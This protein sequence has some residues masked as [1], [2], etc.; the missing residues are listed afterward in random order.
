LWLATL[1]CSWSIFTTNTGPII[2]IAPNELDVNDADVIALYKQ[3]RT[4]LKSEFYDGSTAIKPN[5]FGTRDED[6][7]ALRRRQMAHSFSTASMTRM[8]EISDRNVVNI[9]M[10]L[11]KYAKSREVF[12]LSTI[13]AFFG[14]DV[15][16]E[17]SYSTRYDSQKKDDP[18]NLLP[19]NEH[20]L[21]SCLIG[22]IPSL[23]PVLVKYGLFLPW[24]CDMLTGR[25]W[26]RDT[27]AANTAREYQNQADSKNY[28]LLTSLIKAKDPE[29]GQILEEVDV[30]TEAFAFL[31]AGS[32]TTYGSPVML[33]KHVFDRLDIRSTVCQE[34]DENLPPTAAG[35][36]PYPGL[37]AK[38]PHMSATMKES[39]RLTPIFQLPL[40]RV[41]P[42]GGHMM[43]GQHLP[44]GTIV[45]SINY[46]IGHNR[47]I[48]GSDVEE[49]DLN[50]WLKGE[51]ADPNMLMAFGAGHRACIGRNM[52]M[53]SMWKVSTALPRNYEFLP[54]P[55]TTGGKIEMEAKGFAELVG[56]L[57]CTC[58][59][60]DVRPHLNF[61]LYAVRKAPRWFYTVKGRRTTRMR[62]SIAAWELG[63][64]PCYGRVPGRKVDYLKSQNS[65]ISAIFFWTTNIYPKVLQHCRIA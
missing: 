12:D 39:F 32:H 31:V 23:K 19:I 37:E 46:C 28:N 21:L 59:F 22:V 43:A 11:D 8:D 64:C 16:G 15:N 35:V 61:E 34:L 14:H 48:W 17:L 53:M 25:K 9:R 55:G 42:P 5:L 63:V 3:G 27:A 41:I 62:S 13:F 10:K 54:V 47:D 7:H 24:V 50:R 49:F 60:E 2:R 51:C 56:G 30:A 44:G 58:Q 4:A 36:Y 38:L 45:S 1:Q 52:A 33:F 6:L 65:Q 20:I 29:T 40:P 18:A 26:L 57:K